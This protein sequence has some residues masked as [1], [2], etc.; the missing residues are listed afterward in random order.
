VNP[1]P[2]GL[3]PFR[4]AVDRIG[5]LLASYTY[6]LDASGHRTSVTELN[7]RKH[8]YTYDNLYR[9]TQE[10]ITVGT[11]DPAIAGTI[12]YTLDRVG[13]R[14]S[15]SSSVPSVASVVGSYDSNDRL[16][17]DTYDADGNTLASADPRPGASGS[18]SDVY[19]F[20]NRLISRNSGAIKLLYDCD[21]NRVSETVG[22]QTI[23]YLVDALN[24]T[25]YAQVVE[26]RANGTL[27]RTYAYGHALI[28]Q[29]QASVSP[30]WTTTYYAFDGR[31]ST[32]LLTDSSGNV[33]DTY[34]YDAFGV[35]IASTTANAQPTFNRYRYVGE[36]FDDDLGLLYLR[37]RYITPSTGRFWTMD[38]YESNGHNPIGL[39]KYLY[40]QADPVGRID[41]S[42]RFSLAEISVS[43]GIGATLNVA[44]AIPNIV[45]NWSSLTAGDIA[46]KLG[47]EAAVGAATGVIGGVAGKLFFKTVTP[48]VTWLFQKAIIEGSAGAAAQQ[49]ATELWDVLQGKPV[50]IKDAAGR[51]FIATLVGALGGGATFKIEPVVTKVLN[52]AVRNTQG[53]L[54]RIPWIEITQETISWPGVGGA[55]GAEAVTD[56]IQDGV[57]MMGGFDD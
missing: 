25:G 50:T 40:A 20:E 5:T 16:T 17:S 57:E 52:P 23:T 38:S 33:T 8:T 4:R 31:G 39:H 29:T 6:T 42:G 18:V 45:R 12:A 22:P 36:Q 11:G 41:P 10:T 2:H 9:L 46:K 24:P 56:W 27:V 34:A 48:N 3:T 51:V 55:L 19:D 7:Q 49:V 54:V 21:G 13:N 35:Q 43:A 15:R 44:L 47:T 1:K 53:F 32:R 28:S 14:L 30:G 26:E 37:A